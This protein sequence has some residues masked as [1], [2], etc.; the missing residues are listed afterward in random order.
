LVTDGGTP[1]PTE[2][3][4]HQLVIA[5]TQECPTPSWATTVRIP[6]DPTKESLD[7]E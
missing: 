2:P 1:W 3:T 7:D 6:Q 4:R 5:L